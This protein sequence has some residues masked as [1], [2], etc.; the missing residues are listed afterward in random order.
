M[1]MCSRAL[2]MVALFVLPAFAAGPESAPDEQLM[3]PTKNG[4]RLTPDMARAFAGQWLAENLSEHVK[5]TDSEQMKLSDAAAQR[6]MALARA[7]QRD[8]SELLEFAM[9]NLMASRGKFTR[10]MSVEFAQ[11]LTP[12]IPALSDFTDGVNADAGKLLPA[13]KAAQVQAR[14]GRTRQALDILAGKMQRWSQGQFQDG[15]RPLIDSMEEANK[16]ADGQ[17]S[18]APPKPPAM[19]RAQ[20]VAGFQLNQI[21]PP[22][23]RHFLAG[24]ERLF[25]FSPEQAAKGDKLLAAYTAKAEATMTPAWREKVRQNRIRNSL[26]Y[27]LPREELGPWLFHIAQ[28]YDALLKPVQTLE[29]AFRQDVLALATDQQR[30]AVLE[31]VR[32]AAAGLG[33]TGEIDASLLGLA[34]N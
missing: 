4:I 27:N 34:G 14:L 30:A 19:R 13:A 11:R 33:V 20:R 7:H 25:G 24:V 3:Q 17:P 1:K 9:E 10:E 31:K 16:A 8:G 32:T 6:L 23:W 29:A 28:E 5:L 12:I 22:S 26:Q 15:E 21:G 18:P 2:A